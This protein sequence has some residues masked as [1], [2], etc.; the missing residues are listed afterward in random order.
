[1][2][3]RG[4]IAKRDMIRGTIVLVVILSVLCITLFV[5]YQHLKKQSV[6]NAEEI[7][8]LEDKLEQQEIRAEQLQQKEAEQQT[9]AFVEETARK[10]FNLVM[11][12]DTVI[13]SNE[14]E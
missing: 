12:G 2:M 3:S 7:E 1:M 6:A 14:Q 13:K 5:R 9:D 11:P 8:L 4:N 10:H